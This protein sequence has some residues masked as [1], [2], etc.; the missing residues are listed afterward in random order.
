M[1]KVYLQYQIPEV[2]AQTSEH[3]QN[4]FHATYLLDKF[5][6]ESSIIACVDKSDVSMRKL[7]LN[8]KNTAGRPV[9]TPVT[10]T[11][12]PN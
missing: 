8:S 9:M 12:D 3:I 10:F 11:N 7:F 1:H 6:F 5:E 2:F 4:L